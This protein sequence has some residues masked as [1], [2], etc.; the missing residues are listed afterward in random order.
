[1]HL[2]F[3]WLFFIFLLLFLTT[4][5]SPVEP[6]LSLCYHYC[7]HLFSRCTVCKVHTFL[8]VNFTSQCPFKAPKQLI[9]T[10]NTHLVLNGHLKF[11]CTGFKLSP[12]GMAVHLRRQLLSDHTK[13]QIG[14]FIGPSYPFGHL[15]H[16]HQ[17]L[18]PKP[19]FSSMEGSYIG[20]AIE[21]YPLVH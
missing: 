16:T 8:Y 14:S 1:M 15:D 10:T 12:W 2:P 18:L 21:M 17:L 3:D 20:P 11:F 19:A 9:N 7:K 5:N 13:W 4:V 6:C